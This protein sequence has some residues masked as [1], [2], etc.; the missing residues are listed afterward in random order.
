AA[1]P[2]LKMWLSAAAAKEEA[3][4]EKEASHELVRDARRKPSQPPALRLAPAAVRGLQVTT[5]VVKKADQPRPLPAQIGT[6]AYDL[7][8]RSPVKSHLPGQLLEIAEVPV[9][10]ADEAAEPPPPLLP[11]AE[12]EKARKK[13]RPLRFGDKVKAGDLLAVVL[14]KELGEQKAALVGA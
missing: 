11:T 2:M 3:A 10:P 5:A 6:L 8:H 14:S 13:T 12:R 9:Q 7:H 4:P 1:M